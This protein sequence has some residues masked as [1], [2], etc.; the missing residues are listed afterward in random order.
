VVVPPLQPP[1]HA[2]AHA[3]SK[4]L[5]SELGFNQQRFVAA[6]LSSTGSFLILDIVPQDVFRATETLDIDHH[7]SGK[8]VPLITQALVDRAHG[9]SG[10]SALGHAVDSRVGVW[11]QVASKQ[12][13]VLLSPSARAVEVVPSPMQRRHGLKWLHDPVPY[14]VVAVGVILLCGGYLKIRRLLRKDGDLRRTITGLRNRA[15]YT[16]LNN[17]EDLDVISKISYGLNL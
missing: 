14:V 1:V 9:P 6:E 15:A 5:S 17:W 11:R 10:L 8:Q 7:V 16:G 2:T 4:A 3:W 13:S 12:P